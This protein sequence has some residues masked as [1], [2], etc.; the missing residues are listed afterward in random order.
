MGIF[1]RTFIFIAFFVAMPF[2][3]QAQTAD[4]LQQKIS[5][6]NADI[7]RLEQE[8]AAYQNE[9]AETGKEKDTLSKSLKQLDLNK[10]SLLA[11]INLTEDKIG[12]KNDELASLSEQITVT[13]GQIDVNKEVVKNMIKR[14]N[15]RGDMSLFALVASGGSIGDIWKEIDRIAAL[16]DE[17]TNSTTKLSESKVMLEL[18]Q[19]EVETIKQDLEMLKESQNDQKKIVEQNANEKSQLL[20]ETKNKESEYQKLLAE[21]KKQKEQFASE[22]RDYENKLAFILDPSKL[23]PS[24]TG[25]LSW[26]L[27][28]VYITQLFGKTVAAQRLYAS[29]SHNGIDLN[30]KIGTPVKAMADGV[31]LGTGDTDVQ[32][33][34]VSFGRFV[35]IKYDNG[36]SSTFGHLSVIKVTDGQRVSRGEVVG[37]SGNT[38]YST[39]PHLHVSVYANGSVEVKT[40]PSKSCKGKVL[41][42]PIAATNGY[43]DPMLYLPPKN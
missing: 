18:H 22:L 27:D 13:G 14:L 23:P 19:L 5:T 32:C 35:T 1:K 11:E 34:G 9:L 37:L 43:L 33:K 36:L 40:L 31:V 29:G 25:I 3:L 17:L 41:T 2:L 4:E 6:R 12:E 8:I 42:Q 10:K 30:A 26:P 16:N 38:G 20:K 21:K 15:E 39:G 28:T 7:V 24:G